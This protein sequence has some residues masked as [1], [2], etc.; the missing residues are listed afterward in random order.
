MPRG[1]RWKKGQP[2]VKGAK[3]LKDKVNTHD[4]ILEDTV[5]RVYDLEFPGKKEGLAEQTVNVCV[6]GQPGTMKVL[7]RP[8][9]PL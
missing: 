8:A 7:G 9:V 4:D 3:N 5:D 6:N 2:L 1:D